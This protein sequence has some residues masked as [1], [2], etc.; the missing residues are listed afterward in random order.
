MGLPGTKMTTERLI[1]TELLQLKK[2]VF[3]H[4]SHTHTAI[5]YIQYGFKLQA[6]DK[7][8][9]PCVE[10]N[11]KLISSLLLW[12]PGDRDFTWLS[13]NYTKKIYTLCFAE[14]NHFSH[15]CHPYPSFVRGMHSPASSHILPITFQCAVRHARSVLGKKHRIYGHFLFDSIPYRS[16]LFRLQSWSALRSRGPETECHIHL[17]SNRLW[18]VA[19]II[20][21]TYAFLACCV[22][23]QFPFGDQ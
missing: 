1:F 18:T 17:C 13:F 12:K 2:T 9:S 8:P 10:R 21:P 3:I 20:N 15:F 11:E 14:S 4:V 5:V 23:L 19:Y 16:I 6:L 7:F 22:V